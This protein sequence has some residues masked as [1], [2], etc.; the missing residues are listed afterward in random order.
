MNVARALRFKGILPIQFWGEY[1]LVECHL[2]NRTLPNVNNYLT[3]NKNLYGE[4]PRFHN[5]KFLVA[6][7]MHIINLMMEINL[8][9]EVKVYFCGVSLWIKGMKIV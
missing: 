2:I 3:P 4:P 7:V 9:V 5:I 1:V 6:C 8:P